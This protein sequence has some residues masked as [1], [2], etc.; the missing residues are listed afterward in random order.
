MDC[1]F[2]STSARFITD[3]QHITLHPGANMQDHYIPAVQ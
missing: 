2:K 3:N 1:V